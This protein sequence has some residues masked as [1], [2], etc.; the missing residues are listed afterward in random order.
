M[1]VGRTCFCAV[2]H[3]AGMLGHQAGQHTD[4]S[5]ILRVRDKVMMSHDAYTSWT[6][7]LITVAS[8]QR[9]KMEALIPVPADCEVRSVLKW[10]NAQSIAPIEIHR[11]LCRVYGHTRPNW[12]H[13]SCRSLAG[14]S[15]I[16]IHPIAWNS[17]QVIWL[18]NELARSRSWLLV[19]AVGA[20][21]VQNMERRVQMCLDVRGRY[22]QHIL[23]GTSQRYPAILDILHYDLRNLRAYCTY[24]LL[25]LNA[26]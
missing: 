6:S 12:Q 1:K 13:F 9:L 17:H 2:P 24:L 14:R 18:G 22:F 15:L 16:I 23:W 19:S 20:C 11:Q 3:S 7:R 4:F 26:K 10:S 5:I 21:V 8:L 25:L